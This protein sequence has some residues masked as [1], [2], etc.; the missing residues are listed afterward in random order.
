MGLV[1][2]QELMKERRQ[3]G[4]LLELEQQTLPWAQEGNHHQQ[5][6][7]EFAQL[8]MLRLGKLFYSCL[9]YT[10]ILGMIL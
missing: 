7:G 8:G 10:I 1:Q 4:R 5:V 9:Q 6:G 2:G 3:A